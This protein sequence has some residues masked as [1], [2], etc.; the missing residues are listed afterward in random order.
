[1]LWRS[2][3]ESNHMRVV[4]G[5]GGCGFVGIPPAGSR[6]LLLFGYFVFTHA[7]DGILEMK[8]LCASRFGIR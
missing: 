2:T 8:T 4:G 6:D 3:D 5:A 7:V 1:M